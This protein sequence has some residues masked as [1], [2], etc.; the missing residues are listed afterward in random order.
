MDAPFAVYWGCTIAH[1]LPFIESAT[2]RALALLE[3]ELRDVEGVSC[4]PDPLYARLLGDETTLALAARNLTLASAV[5]ENLLVVCNGCWQS[6][7]GAAAKLAFPAA[8]AATNDRLRRANAPTYE[9]PVNV[10]HILTLLTQVGPERVARRVTRPLAGIRVA[11]HYGCHALAPAPL[12]A[13]D[14]EAPGIMEETLRA[15]GARPVDYDERLACCGGSL[16]AADERAGLALLDRKL[17]NLKRAGA[18]AIV[19]TCP[20]CFLQ[21]DLRAKMV[22]EELRL[23]VFHLAELA[24]LA[25][26]VPVRDLRFKGWHAVRVEP[27]LNKIGLS[28]EGGEDLR[29]HFN[30]ASLAACC[31]AC[32]HECT[33]VEGQ[34][35][36]PIRNRYNPMDIV[37]RV[38]AGEIE[39]LLSSPE[40]WYCIGC[41]ECTRRCP[42][43]RGLAGMFETLRRLAAARGEVPRWVAARVGSV[44]ETGLTLNRQDWAREEFGLPPAPTPEAATVKKVIHLN[45]E[46]ESGMVVR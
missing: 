18:E 3:I 46:D 25:F 17:K 33:V 7:A 34:A 28:A 35:A 38:V 45:E 8:R 24:C 11:A 42:L 14:A 6:L 16:V 10:V 43:N 44:R 15:L 30:V 5:A 22:A 19:V 39:P 26:G 36:A 12:A 9:R 41:Q 1:R 23:P 31:G 4:C 27:L 21:F 13:D 2:R 40:I 32:E 29:S 37:R 20:S